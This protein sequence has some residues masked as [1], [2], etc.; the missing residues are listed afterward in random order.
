MTAEWRRSLAAPSG[1]L[2]VV[3]GEILER[4]GPVRAAV[5][6]SCGMTPSAPSRA[7]LE[8]SD[9]LGA[10]LEGGGAS[11]HSPTSE[12]ATRLRGGCSGGAVH[13]RLA[14]SAC[15]RLAARMRGW[16]SG[17]AWNETSAALR[18]LGE[19]AHCA[20]EGWLAHWFALSPIRRVHHSRRSAQGRSPTNA[21]WFHVEQ[22]AEEGSRAGF[23]DR[24]RAAVGSCLESREGAA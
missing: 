21:R 5:S 19:A 24:L 9:S 17:L 14:R 6:D 1:L 15:A 23:S 12:G 13:G 8:P 11:W 20:R 22:P 7:S 16:T 10:A 2:D 3:D 18:S 4:E